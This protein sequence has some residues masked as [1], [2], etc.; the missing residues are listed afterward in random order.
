MSTDLEQSSGAVSAV[1]CDDWKR[2]ALNRDDIACTRAATDDDDDDNVRLGN[3]QPD[4]EC[5]AATTERVNSPSGTSSNGVSAPPSAFFAVPPRR[6]VFLDLIDT[7]L[8]SGLGSASTSAASSTA[9]RPD[10]DFTTPCAE[11]QVRRLFS[12]GLVDKLCEEVR[13]VVAAEQAMLDVRVVEDETL[14]VVGDIHGNLSDLVAHVLSEQSDRQLNVDG[15]DRKFLFLGDFVDRGPCGVEVVMLLFA[16]KVEYPQ[17]IYMTRGNHEDSQTSRFY[18]FF[19]EVLQKFGSDAA[20][21]RF[22]EVFCYLP[23]AA[24][25]TTPRK[26]FFASHGGLSPQLTSS[27]DIIS[28]IERSDYGNVL[29]NVLNEVVDG[30][31]WSDPTESTPLYARNVRGRGYLFGVEASQEFCRLNKFDFICRAHQVVSEGY[32]WTHDGKVLTVFSVPNYCGYNNNLGAVMTVQ[33]SQS[34]KEL[35]FKQFTSS[36]DSNPSSPPPPK[37]LT[38]FVFSAFLE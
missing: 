1:D 37:Q 9:E 14:V 24:V 38:E 28:T 6:G 25:V 4:G 21:V 10:S 13:A 12:M 26:R 29:D 30:L 27:V 36:I 15:S 23:L 32:A 3:L 33:P 2:D 22:N 18:G 11:D 7:L 17:L 8:H 16:L 34:E 5:A 19:H 31:L 35:Y 20:W